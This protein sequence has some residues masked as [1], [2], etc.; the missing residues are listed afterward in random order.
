MQYIFISY[1]FEM[2]VQRLRKVL[3]RKNSAVKLQSYFY[4]ALGKVSMI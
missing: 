4:F 1:D 2:H 3:I